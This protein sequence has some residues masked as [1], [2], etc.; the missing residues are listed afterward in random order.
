LIIFDRSNNQKLTE[1]LSKVI[2]GHNDGLADATYGDKHTAG[3]AL[4]LRLR[5]KPLVN[6]RQELLL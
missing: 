2:G 4:F 3:A 6:V 5:R 1:E